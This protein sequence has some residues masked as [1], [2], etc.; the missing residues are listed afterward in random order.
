MS[1][2]RPQIERLLLD[3]L[4]GG[5]DVDGL[6]RLSQLGRLGAQLV[7]Q[8]AIEEEVDAFLRR[9]RYER[10]PDGPRL[11]QRPPATPDR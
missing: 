2:S 6:D 7:L 8:R 3:G 5:G 1:R 11:A 4:E 10:T 9:A